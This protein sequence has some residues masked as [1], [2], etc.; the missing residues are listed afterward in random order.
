MKLISSWSL[1]CRL[2]YIDSLHSE[3]AEIHP[4]WNAHLLWVWNFFLYANTII[5]RFIEC[6]IH[7]MTSHTAALWQRNSFCWRDMIIIGSF[8]EYLLVLI[9]NS[10]AKSSW[11]DRFM[12]WFKEGLYL[13]PVGKLELWDF[14]L[15]DNIYALKQ[16][17]ALVLFLINHNI[18][19]WVKG[20]N[21]MVSS[22]IKPNNHTQ[23]YVSHSY[24]F[25]LAELR[26]LSSWRLYW[27]LMIPPAINWTGKRIMLLCGLGWLIPIS[28]EDLGGYD[29]MR[30]RR[31]NLEPMGFSRVLFTT[32][33]PNNKS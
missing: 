15:Q 22:L 6:H 26:C 17:L 18:V 20:G 27:P 24:N 9:H 28:K 14:L 5:H 31:T 7:F 2:I 1:I 8:I 10:F 21:E 4:H 29:T 23:K 33:V 19:I 32:S 13:I 16:W 3:G 11:F 25:G 12:K 30:T